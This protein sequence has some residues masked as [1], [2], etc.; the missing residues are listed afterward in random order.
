MLSQIVAIGKST[1]TMLPMAVI[2]SK[3]KW[4]Y[5]HKIKRRQKSCQNITCFQVNSRRKRKKTPKWIRPT[6]V[7]ETFKKHPIPAFSAKSHRR[8]LPRVIKGTSYVQSE[9]SYS[10][11]FL[12]LLSKGQSVGRF[13]AVPTLSRNVTISFQYRFRI[14][15]KQ[16]FNA[17]FQAYLASRL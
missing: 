1:K 17:T 11:V 6:L 10:V 3:V 4:I 9:A 14:Q 13:P 12:Q 2:W 16:Q 5:Y 15:C 8:S 7:S